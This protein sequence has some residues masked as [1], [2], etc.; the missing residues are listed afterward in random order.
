MAG[1][2]VFLLTFPEEFFALRFGFASPGWLT[3]VAGKGFAAI[4]VCAYGVAEFFVIR[5]VT[6]A[7]STDVF[8]ADPPRPRQ[9]AWRGC[10]SDRSLQRRPIVGGYNS[11]LRVE[12]WREAVDA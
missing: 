9:E 5:R 1:P 6:P 2:A 3:E 8:S 10:R 12:E 4:A 7:L 11:P